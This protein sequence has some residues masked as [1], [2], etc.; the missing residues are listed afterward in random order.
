MSKLVKSKRY[1][2]VYRRK[3]LD[4]ELTY[5]YTY[6]D[7]EN[8]IHYQK[9]GTKSQGITESYVNDIRLRTVTSIKLDELPPKIVRS[10][11]KNKITVDEISEFYFTHN[12]SKSRDKRQRQYNYRLK[13]FFGHMNIYDVNVD[14]LEKFKKFTLEDVS[15]QTTNIYL[16]LLSTIFNYYRRKHQLKMKNPVMMIDKVRVDNVW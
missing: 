4:G 13:S 7:E 11:S 10:N 14:H 12:N 15:E 6:K 1:K 2:G 9:V 8:K 5:Y 3:S 16:E